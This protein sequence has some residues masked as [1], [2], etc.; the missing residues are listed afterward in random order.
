MS[1]PIRVKAG[2][3]GSFT[4]SPGMIADSLTFAAENS[5]LAPVLDA[6]EWCC[7]AEPAVEKVELVR[8]KDATVRLVDGQPPGR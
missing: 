3:A 2:R 5:T 1:A 7:A 6:A 8:P 4:I